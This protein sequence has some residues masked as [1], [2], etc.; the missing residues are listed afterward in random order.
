MKP[1]AESNADPL[2][3]L[4]TR[5]GFLLRMAHQRARAIF[6]QEMDRWR[7]TNTQY[8]LLIA[9]ANGEVDMIGAARLIGVDRTTAHVALSNMERD[10]RIRR[11][12]DPRDRR[13]HVLAGL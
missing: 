10:G 5:P 7:V 13:R 8:T 9:I 4:S 3:D 11:V 1:S 6:Q 12:K 2:V